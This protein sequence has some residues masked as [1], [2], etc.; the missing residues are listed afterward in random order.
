MCGIV[1]VW[2]QDGEPVTPSLLERMT[3]AL[4]HRGPDDEGW[5]IDG[6]VAL[7]HRRLA[8][9]DLSSRGH[10]PM[11]N[12]TGEVLI[13]YNG[14]IY[15]FGELNSELEAL[16]HRFRSESDTETIVHAYEEW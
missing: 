12:E 9:L 5:F 3:D 15:N 10:Q 2:H 16:G 8:I 13:T 11:P 7:G 14:E 6:P 4:A 1:G